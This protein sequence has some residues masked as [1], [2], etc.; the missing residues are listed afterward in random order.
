MIKISWGQRNRT[1]GREPKESS[2]DDGNVLG[3]GIGNL[4]AC[5]CNISSSCTLKIGT[6]YWPA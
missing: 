3:G 5:L 6:F 4:N 1:E 2:W